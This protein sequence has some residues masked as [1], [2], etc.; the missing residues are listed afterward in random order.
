MEQPAEE[1][2]PDP[3]DAPAHAEA[4]EVVDA[5]YRVHGETVAAICR[6]LLRDSWEAEDAMQQVFLSAHRA[7]LRGVVP[8]KPDAWLATIARRECWAHARA[9]RAAPLP[10]ADAGLGENVAAVERPDSE[11]LAAV[12]AGIAQLPPRQR[13]ALLLREIRG[14]SYDQLAERLA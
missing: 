2:L 8:R 7:V 6:T 10:T 4:R 11:E 5:L 3:A 12:W 9:R 14:L 13:D 1:R